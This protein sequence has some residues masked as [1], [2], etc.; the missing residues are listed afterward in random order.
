MKGIVFNLL[1]EVVRYEFGEATW[2]ALLD[3]ARLE[4]TYTSL[5]N[6]PDADMIRLVAAAS[7]V[8]NLPD[9]HVLRWFGRHALTLLADR[10]R[11][12]SGR[13]LP[14]ARSCSP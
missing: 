6:Y 3:A 13:S 9:D 14:P 5:G 1:E 7:S 8:L 4:G 12:S 10:Y 11:S 2:D